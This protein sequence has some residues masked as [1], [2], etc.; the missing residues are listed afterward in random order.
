MSVVAVVVQTIGSP[1]K[2]AVCHVS[3]GTHAESDPGHL[4]LRDSASHAGMHAC[5]EV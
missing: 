4:K 5:A 1:A 2:C 3:T